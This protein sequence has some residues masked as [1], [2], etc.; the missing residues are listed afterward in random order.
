MIFYWFFASQNWFVEIKTRSTTFIFWSPQDYQ[1][2]EIKTT[3]NA[4]SFVILDCTKS[5]NGCWLSRL[6]VESR[7]IVQRKELL[8][9]FQ[10]LQIKFEMENINKELE[11]MTDLLIPIISF[12]SLCSSMY[13]HPLPVGVGVHV[14]N[15]CTYPHLN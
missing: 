5:N 8:I 2:I 10:I 9:S 11:L 4:S 3:T 1:P 7:T 12:L 15:V 14:E 13:S 6:L